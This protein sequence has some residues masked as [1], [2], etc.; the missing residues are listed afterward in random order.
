MIINVDK[1]NLNSLLGVPNRQL[2]IPAYQRPYAWEFEQVDEL[3]HDIVETLGGNHFMG[4]VVMCSPDNA[5]PEVIDGQQRLTTIILLLALIRDKYQALK[6]ELVGRVQQFFEN[7]YAPADL[8]FKFRPGNANARVFTDFILCAPDN[9]ARGDWAAVR[10]LDSHELNRNKRMIEN[11]E[12][13]S[14]YLDQYL[15]ASDNPLHSLE[16]LETNIMT[17]LEFVVIDVPDIANAFIIFE[18][19][20]DRGLALSAGDLLKNHLLAAA[21]KTNESVEALAQDWDKIIDNLEGGDITRFLRH[22][23]LTQHA[24]VQKDDVFGLFKKEVGTRGVKQLIKDLKQMSRF[25]GQFIKPELVEDA[26]VREVY[27]NLN[28]LRATMCYSAL[29]AASPV[30]N[31]E[32]LRDFARLCE[33]LTFRYSTICSKDSK[34]LERFYHNAAKV[35]ASQGAAGLAEA[36]KA[37]EAASPSSE[38]FVLAFRT[39]SMG[40]QYIVNYIFR[41]IE[42]FLSPDEKTL[43]NTQSVHIEH[44]MPQTLS[45][46]WKEV[47]GEDVGQHESYV[48][49]W[50]NLTLLGGRLNIS[51]SNRL[52]ADKKLSYE[53][54]K[55]ALA[56]ELTS[57]ETWSFEQIDERQE[58]LAV[59]A[60]GIWSI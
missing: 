49:R 3:W 35:L 56:A 36:R 33:L 8:R 55:I 7:A 11:T 18:T 60:E 16:K 54:S 57:Y 48:N 22:Y 37:L 9:A 14:A 24:Q 1:T 34:E 43:L 2:T 39:Q 21:A 17:G 26:A 58:K 5:R 51:A 47:L 6:P 53:Q 52:F 30:L 23:L 42:N 12:R 31:N 59:I 44:I 29:L 41:G 25:Y 40:R 13:L 50:G 10:Q 45:A 32:D 27:Q 19:L 15:A 28:T 38:E 20:N 46:E 4:S